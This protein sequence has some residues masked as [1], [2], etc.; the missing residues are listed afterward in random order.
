MAPPLAGAVAPYHCAV[1]ATRGHARIPRCCR[2]ASPSVSP[3]LLAE[4]LNAKLEIG[5]KCR[6][7]AHSNVYRSRP[8]EGGSAEVVVDGGDPMMQ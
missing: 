4:W 1:L 6:V 7:R 5:E 8:L 3:F 2:L